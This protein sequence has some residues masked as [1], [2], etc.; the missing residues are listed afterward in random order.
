MNVYEEVEA[1]G[2]RWTVENPSTGVYLLEGWLFIYP[3][4]KKWGEKYKQAY[5]FY[6]D[7]ETFVEK[8]LTE[9]KFEQQYSGRE[10]TQGE[11][12]KKIEVPEMVLDLE[13]RLKQFIGTNDNYAEIYGLNERLESQNEAF[14]TVLECINQLKTNGFIDRGNPEAELRSKVKYDKQMYKH[15]TLKDSK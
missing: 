4:S 1:L 6:D 13:N 12:S 15:N 5:G 14:Y 7:L 2:D 3:K 11:R 8:A 9:Y 10:L